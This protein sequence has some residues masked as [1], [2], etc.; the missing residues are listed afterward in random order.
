ME[1][2]LLALNEDVQHVLVLDEHA[3]DVEV[4][5]LQVRDAVKLVSWHLRIGLSRGSWG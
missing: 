2:R 4:D 5:A 3:L 1:S